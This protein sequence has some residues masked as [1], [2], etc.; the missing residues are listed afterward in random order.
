MAKRYYICPIVWDEKAETPAFRPLLALIVDPNTGKRAFSSVQIVDPRSVK[1]VP[2]D[3]W[4]LALADG[5]HDLAVGIEG[6]KP[7][8]AD[9][10]DAVIAK[11]DAARAIADTT[12][13]DLSK[14]TNRRDLIVALGNLQQPNFDAEKFR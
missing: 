8:A 2:V 12:G 6:V 14:V 3:G 9:T 11:D 13:I 1:G 7:I 10:L 4:C 5:N